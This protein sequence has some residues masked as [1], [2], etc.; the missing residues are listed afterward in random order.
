MIPISQVEALALQAMATER[1]LPDPTR[2][3]MGGMF[4]LETEQWAIDELTNMRAAP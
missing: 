4:L 2:F 1:E 3:R